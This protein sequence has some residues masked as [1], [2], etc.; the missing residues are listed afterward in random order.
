GPAS[1]PRCQTT[2]R[3]PPPKAGRLVAFTAASVSLI[4]TKDTTHLI[5][6]CCSGSCCSGRWHRHAAKAINS[7]HPILIEW[8]IDYA[9]MPRCVVKTML[10]DHH[11]YMGQ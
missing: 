1:L 5:G 6:S 8:G 9:M 2:V 11:P 10:I 7:R 4:Q 3:L